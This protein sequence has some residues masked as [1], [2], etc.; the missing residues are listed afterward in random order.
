[1]HTSIAPR[2]MW[3]AW[4]IAAARGDERSVPSACPASYHWLPM[5][6]ATR[7]PTMPPLDDVT[8]SKATFLAMCVRNAME[9]T[10]HGGELGELSLTDE[11][12]AVLN[13]IVRNAIATGLHALTHQ[14]Y[15]LVTR[16]IAFQQMLV[17]SYWERPKLLSDYIEAVGE[18]A[19]D[20]HECRHCGRQVIRVG[21]GW[22]HLSANGGL[23]VGCRAASFTPGRGWD[24]T[25]DRSLKA[26]P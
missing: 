4:A 13:P 24:D 18:I 3:P 23:N 12:M 6:K 26:A 17:P 7:P 25:L 8:A 10:I 22:R 14:D 20:V 21:T 9:G 2:S 5:T 1:M 19:R 16:Y 11:Q 15:P